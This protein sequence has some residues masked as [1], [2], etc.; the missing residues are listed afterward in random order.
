MNLV[1]IDGGLATQRAAH[2]VVIAQHRQGARR[3]VAHLRILRL[4]GGCFEKAIGSRVRIHG[5][6]LRTGPAAGGGFE[7]VAELP[8]P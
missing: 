8:L 5:G 6:S 3:K 1:A 7:V 4:L 2:R